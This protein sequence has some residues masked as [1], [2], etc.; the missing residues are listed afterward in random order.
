MTQLESLIERVRSMNYPASISLIAGEIQ[1][2][3]FFPGGRGAFDKTG[4]I[5][6]KISLTKNCISAQ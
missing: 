3:A 1:R 2:T 6:C 4:D 5:S